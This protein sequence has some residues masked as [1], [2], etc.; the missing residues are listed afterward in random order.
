ME[1]GLLGE[2]VNF[3][4]PWLGSSLLPFGLMSEI[5]RQSLW[6][7]VGCGWR[8]RGLAMSPGKQR[9]TSNG[10]DPS[11]PERRTAPGSHSC[12]RHTPRPS[13]DPFYMYM[14]MRA[15]RFSRV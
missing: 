3:F 10:R 9:S 7:E 14:C 6:Q 13:S 15:S 11:K 2:T 5:E 12:V 8:G 1:R 4:H